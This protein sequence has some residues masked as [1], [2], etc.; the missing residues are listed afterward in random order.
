MNV[1]NK[2]LDNRRTPFMTPIKSEIMS[3]GNNNQPGN[4]NRLKVCGISGFTLIELMVVVAIIAILAAIALPSY[5]Q[6]VIKNAERESQAK[7]LQ[8]QIQLERWRAKSLSYRGFQP[9]IINSA[10]NEVSYGYNKDNKIIY[11]PDGSDGTN[12]RYQ[13]TL[14]EGVSSIDPD[15]KKVTA[16]SL[17][18]PVTGR[19]WKMFA[20]P[21]SSY[22]TG[23][24]MLLGSDGLQCKTKNSNS[25]ITVTSINC[26]TDSEDW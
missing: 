20:E 9:Q 16:N 7:M 12:Y 15:S 18:T 22:N 19:S 13:I 14:V 26:G 23:H 25:D 1:L 10:N 17:M 4:S 6:Y 5:R 8:L 24:K 21:S 2:E 11:V 3:V